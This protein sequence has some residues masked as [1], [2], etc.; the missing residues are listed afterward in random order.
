M[1][2]LKSLT[3]MVI[4]RR[5]EGFNSFEGYDNVDPDDPQ[6]HSKNRTLFLVSVDVKLMNHVA[7]KM[8]LSVKN[9]H[10]GFLEKFEEPRAHEYERFRS[11]HIQAIVQFLFEEEFDFEDYL[12]TGLLVDHFPLHNYVERNNIWVYWKLKSPRLIWKTI[13]YQSSS[14][15]QLRPLTTLSRYFGSK[16]GWFYTFMSLYAPDLA[17]PS[18]TGVAIGIYGVVTY[19]DADAE[20]D[21]MYN[22]KALPI[23]GVIISL[24]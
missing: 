15:D 4:L 3:W 17:F 16:I 5:N 23:M 12:R 18:L 24:W 1:E 13:L 9:K 20:I 21:A 14:P 8:G 19:S 6:A 22:N 10:Y 7:D 11:N 2:N